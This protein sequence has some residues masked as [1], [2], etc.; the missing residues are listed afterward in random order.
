MEIF[1]K[2]AEKH[3][4]P[5]KNE[6]PEFSN[7][8][9]LVETMVTFKALINEIPINHTK[10]KN[11]RDKRDAFCLRYKDLFLQNKQ[12]LIEKIESLK[13]ELLTQKLESMDTTKD[14]PSINIDD[15]D[16]LS[17]IVEVAYRVRSNLVHGSKT[18]SSDRNKILIENSFKFMYLLLKLILKEENII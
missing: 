11:D 10:S 5:T 16:N 2:E 12:K 4:N 15:T 8:I 13:N 7:V 18:L 6:H 17:E 1:I 14:R 9:G 3:F